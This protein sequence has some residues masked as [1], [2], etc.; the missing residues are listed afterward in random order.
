MNHADGRHQHRQRDHQSGDEGSTKISKKREQNRDDEQCTFGEVGL[1]GCDGAIDQLGAIENR[2]NADTGRQSFR[3]LGHAG[4]P[5]ASISSRPAGR[6]RSQTVRTCWTRRAALG[7]EIEAICN[8]RQTCGKCQVT[9]EEGV[10]S[11]H[12]IASAP[13]IC[14][15]PT[16]A[17]RTISINTRRCRAGGWRAACEVTAI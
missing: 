14:R 10:F 6:A 7:V 12:G 3:N 11:K 5:I 2:L 16:V 1:D 4:Y 13:D 17:R 8:G 9:V 15:R